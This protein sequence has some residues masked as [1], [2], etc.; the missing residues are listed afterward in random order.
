MNFKNFALRALLVLPLASMLSSCTSAPPEDSNS[1]NAAA[2]S[3]ASAT[4]LDGVKNYLI[5]N[6]DNVLKVNAE[7]MQSAADK[8]YQAVEAANFDYHKAWG[9]GKTLRP[10]LLQMRRNFIDAH[11]GYE[12]IEGIVAGV[13]ALSNYDTILD[14]GAPGKQ[15]GEDVAEYSIT[16][17]DGKKLEKPGNHFHNLLEPMIFG[18][19]KDHIALKGVDV[20]GDGKIGFGDAL[21]DANV[22]KGTVDSFVT[23]VDEAMKA[24]HAWQP[25]KQDAFTALVTM[26]PTMSEYFGNWKESR[27]VTGPAST[28]P[29]FVAK[30]RLVDVTQILDSLHTIYGGV[31][32]EVAAKDPA[33]AK[34]IS[35][36]YDNLSAFVKDI[37]AKE[38]AGKKYTP[39]QADVLG[40]SAQNQAQAITGQVAQAAAL[41]NIKVAD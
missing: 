35:H 28:E 15:G 25:S 6:G 10:L 19:G 31:R 34:Q 20:N 40:A 12:S 33:A 14:A 3:P 36:N 24:V 32:E 22:L 18:S 38:R 5:D 41:L 8:Y 21:P 39:D 1:A 11:T 23:Y 9:D 27:F 4:K 13:P 7:K 17:P 30:S 2:P 16:L 37:L 29:A 26:T